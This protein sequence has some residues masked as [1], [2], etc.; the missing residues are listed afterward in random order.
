MRPNNE[1]DRIVGPY[2]G[3]QKVRVETRVNLVSTRVKE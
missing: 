2:V 1:D 3:I